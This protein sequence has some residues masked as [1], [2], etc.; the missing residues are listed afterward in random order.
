MAQGVALLPE[1][2]MLILSREPER[3]IERLQSHSVDAVDWAMLAMSCVLGLAIGW[4]NIN[5]QQH[6]TATAMQ[7]IGTFNR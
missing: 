3:W 4:A 6:I 2:A 7:A 5:A 1:A